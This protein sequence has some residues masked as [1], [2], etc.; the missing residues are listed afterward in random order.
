M[1][2]LLLTVACG[3][4][5]IIG[6]PS[7]C[8]RSQAMRN[9]PELAAGGGRYCFLITDD[10]LAAVSHLSVG[11]PLKQPAI[12]G[13]SNLQWLDL[14]GNPGTPFT[15]TPSPSSQRQPGLW[16]MPSCAPVAPRIAGSF[17]ATQ[18]RT[19]PARYA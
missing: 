7:L 4:L 9:V 13:L 11:V 12:A 15:I 8:D 5:P 10:D 19:T 18:I 14:R 17:P 3:N 1:A 2:A 6:N 16:G